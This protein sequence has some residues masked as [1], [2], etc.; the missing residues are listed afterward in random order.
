MRV[1]ITHHSHLHTSPM[2]RPQLYKPEKLTLEGRFMYSHESTDLVRLTASKATI[3][4]ALLQ[5]VSKAI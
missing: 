3:D 5:L 1:R 4:T 2:S